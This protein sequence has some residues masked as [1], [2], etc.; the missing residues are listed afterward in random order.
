MSDDKSTTITVT[1]TQTYTLYQ[2]PSRFTYRSLPS[3]PG[4][5]NFEMRRKPWP[6]YIYELVAFRIGRLFRRRLR[7]RR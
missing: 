1:G 2:G 7:I 5:T 4:E 3:A 6:R